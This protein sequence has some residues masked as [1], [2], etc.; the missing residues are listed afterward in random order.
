M[1][2]LDDMLAQ[3][4]QMRTRCYRLPNGPW[5]TISHGSY[6]GEFCTIKD[7]DGNDVI[8]WHDMACE[9]WV[10][11]DSLQLGYLA[12]M[13]NDFPDCLDALDEAMRIIDH[14]KVTYAHKAEIIDTYL[15]AVDEAFGIL[16]EAIK[17]NDV[18]QRLRGP[19]AHTG[20]SRLT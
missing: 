2:K 3:I 19:I 1:S 17:N 13:R 11:L 18:N 5:S 15:M 8:S 4:G 7:N 16:S 12:S 10:Y 20:F 9:H 6:E 14:L